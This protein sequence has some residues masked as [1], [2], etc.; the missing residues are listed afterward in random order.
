MDLETYEKHT[1]K[2]LIYKFI[3]MST[4]NKVHIVYCHPSDNSMTN[5]IK[6][7]YITGLKEVS[8][9]YSITDLYKE[10][11]NSDISEY[12]YL[13]ENYGDNNFYEEQI[14]YEQKLIN[15][16]DIL[17]FVFPLFWMDAPSKLVGYFTRIFT[18]G[19]RYGDVESMKTFKQIN[20]IIITGSGF[21]DLKSD[22][23]IDALKTIF[24]ED[25]LNGKSEKFRMFF[26]TDTSPEKEER[27]INKLNYLKKAKII[28]RSSKNV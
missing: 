24:I 3:I 18:K 14:L 12:E 5:L 27:Y 20:F 2:I 10:D 25:R 13:R 23:K 28:G 15:N 1:F 17:T 6:E 21:H 22:G 11:F 19:F 16:S 9:N 7:A 4:M 26:F 8:T